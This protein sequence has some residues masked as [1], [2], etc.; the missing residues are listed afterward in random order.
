MEEVVVDKKI[1]GVIATYTIEKDFRTWNDLGIN[2][3]KVDNLIEFLSL[4]PKGEFEFNNENDESVVEF[5]TLDDID[6]FLSYS[7]EITGD[8]YGKDKEGVISFYV[9]YNGE[10]NHENFKLLVEQ[11]NL[12]DYFEYE[13]KLKKI[14]KKELEKKQSYL[15]EEIRIPEGEDV[16]MRDGGP[17]YSP[18]MLIASVKYQ[19]TKEDDT[20]HYSKDIQITYYHPN[21][22]LRTKI[23]LKNSNYYGGN[24]IEYHDNGKI[25]LIINFPK[26]KRA[27]ELSSNTTD[28]CGFY[29]GDED[30]WYDIEF[31]YKDNDKFYFFS[32]DNYVI[33]GDGY[34]IFKHPFK[35]YD[36]E[37][38][39]IAE[40]D[41][42]MN[43]YEY[44][45][46]GDI[47]SKRT[48]NETFIKDDE[49]RILFLNNKET[50]NYIWHPKQDE[51]ADILLEN[52]VLKKYKGLIEV[53]DNDEVVMLYGRYKKIVKNGDDWMSIEYSEERYDIKGSEFIDNLISECRNEITDYF[54]G[55]TSEMVK[56]K[57]S[58][59][60]NI[61][62][63][64]RRI[65]KLVGAITHLEKTPVV[66]E[67]DREPLDGKQ[68]LYIIGGYR[69]EYVIY[70]R[71]KNHMYDLLSVKGFNVKDDT[72]HNP[73][74][75][76]V[77]RITE[78]EGI[79]GVTQL[80]D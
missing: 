49:G 78:V 36:R 13:I 21:G 64:E 27:K 33:L 29:E 51:K 4:L 38:N 28:V 47:I 73:M 74:G 63:V 72:L 46:N 62:D 39:L 50:K 80:K 30:E 23:A 76:V 77:K 18:N 58:K 2:D 37:G 35:K 20:W 3:F 6:E 60:N 65:E 59:N 67:V 43:F 11:F 79:Y 42:N 45:P 31:S 71:D 69:Y 55:D 26:V 52:G 66:E 41:S 14:P 48:E 9:V 44:K 22:A 25:A 10:D 17:T 53:N 57:N 70:A 19:P 34:N 61:L 40:Q 5:D 12:N 7:M 75:E 56:V 1:G 54:I 15:T 24:F 8:P 32:N 68:K 16:E